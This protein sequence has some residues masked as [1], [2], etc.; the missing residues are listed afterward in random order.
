V[1][2]CTVIHT[3]VGPVLYIGALIDQTSYVRGLCTT[4]HVCTCITLL[5]CGVSVLLHM[6]VHVSQSIRGWFLYSAPT[7]WGL[8]ASN[9]YKP[10]LLAGEAADEDWVKELDLT[11][12]QTFMLEQSQQRP[13]KALVLYGS[14]R[15][16][17]YS[18]LLA[19]EFAR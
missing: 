8:Q 6:C 19:Y 14:L 5:M 18:R 3:C 10:Y 1:L 7:R 4:A 12:A 17:S 2:A 13:L 16:R 11:G 9:A 15:E